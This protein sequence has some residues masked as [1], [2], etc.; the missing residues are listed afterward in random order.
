MNMQENPISTEREVAAAVR[1]YLAFIRNER[2]YSRHTQVAYASDLAK[3]TD[4]M[5][6]SSLPGGVQAPLEVLDRKTLQRF[7][8]SRRGGSSPATQERLVACLKGFGKFLAAR[9][10]LGKNPAQGLLFPRKEK[11]LAAV[12][13]EDFLQGALAAETDGFPSMR[14]RL[15]LEMFYGSGLRLSELVK[16]KW[17]QISRDSRTARVLGKGNKLRTV[18]LTQS[19]RQALDQYREE[20]RSRGLPLDGAVLLSRTGRPLGGR[21]VQKN[22]TRALQEMGRQGKSSPHILRHSFAT[23]LLDNGADLMAV[24]EMLGHSSLSTTQKYTHVS[25]AKLKE[26]Y[27]RAHPRA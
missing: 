1:A 4:W 20:C 27:G 3:L 17:G 2:G 11:K 13:S 9:Y 5:E 21:S 14:T 18:P 24:K 25:V 7:L 8:L 12:A 19:A 6:N 23:H 15:C 16:L 22:V 10:G 26:T